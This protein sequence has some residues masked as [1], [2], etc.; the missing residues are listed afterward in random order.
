[1]LSRFLFAA[2]AA[3]MLASASPLSA[4]TAGTD[5]WYT[6]KVIASYTIGGSSTS[7]TDRHVGWNIKAAGW[8]G[9]IDAQ[10]MTSL[11]WGARRVELHLPFGT[12]NGETADFDAYLESQTAGLT[13][14][15]D[16]FVEAWQPVVQGTRTNGEPVEVIAYMGN[17][18]KDPNFIALLTTANNKIVDKNGV[19]VGV[20]GDNLIALDMDGNV[21]GAAV[22]GD[23]DGKVL[24]DSGQLFGYAIGGTSW[25]NRADA[26]VVP[27]IAAGMSIAFDNGTAFPLWHPGYA[28]IQKIKA[29][30]VKVYVHN[31]PSSSQAQWA[32]ANV[33]VPNTTWYTSW[34]MTSGWP[35]RRAKMTGEQ[36]RLINATGVTTGF[37]SLSNP[38]GYTGSNT[39]CPLL[40]GTLYEAKPSYPLAGLK[41]VKIAYSSEI[42]LPGEDRTE[43]DVAQIAARAATWPTDQPVA[44]D[45]E[46]WATTL[47]AM[48]DTVRKLCLICDTV[49]AANPN[50]KF[51][52]YAS[53]PLRNYFA[54][55]PDYMPG[56]KVYLD[57]QKKRGVGFTDYDYWTKKNE[58]LKE[59]A[60]KVD[61]IFPSLYTF[62]ADQAGWVN[63]AIGNMQQA[64]IYGKPCYPHLLP[65]YHTSAAPPLTDTYLPTDYWKLQLDTV[66][67]LADG[68]VIWGGAHQTWDE[69]APWWTLSQQ[70]LTANSG[71]LTWPQIH[72]GFDE[73]VTSLSNNYSVMLNVNSIAAQ[74]YTLPA[75]INAAK[76]QAATP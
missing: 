5:A 67:P 20:T 51:G 11:N 59:V 7:E 6:Q 62:Y 9:F 63:F 41:P 45:I 49:R 21:V 19:Q 40:D 58:L 27:L 76:A 46:V 53:L 1:M 61:Y 33:I 35:M 70:A 23:R 43:P 72:Y 48:P 30:G 37:D 69:S 24:T 22:P 39:L 47:T 29:Q 28:F 3:V 75:L 25:Q 56:G 66:R 55:Q 68:I 18:Y 16:G 2:C 8:S 60:A 10:V 36:V 50:V 14:L 73:A 65:Q 4:Q 34:F 38:I 71:P 54:P 44:I 74:G 32:D 26:S 57:Q 13:W 31:W 17:L 64:R 15:T 42:W 12:N 52:F